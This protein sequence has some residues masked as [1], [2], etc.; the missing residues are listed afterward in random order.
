MR[1]RLRFLPIA[2]FVVGL[3]LVGVTSFQLHTGLWLEA[4]REIGLAL[5][6][7]G[8]ATLTIE[9]VR[10]KQFSE[11]LQ[12]AVATKLLEIERISADAIMRGPLPRFY[13]EHIKRLML[14]KQTYR[15]GWGINLRLEPAADGLFELSYDQAYTVKNLSAVVHIYELEFLETLD[16][17][18]TDKSRIRFVKARFEHSPHPEV[19]LEASPGETIGNRTEDAIVFRQ[20][21]PMNQG[22]SL[23]VEE[24]SVGWVRSSDMF[25]VPAADP[26][27]GIRCTMD[28]PSTVRVVFEFPEG[29]TRESVYLAAKRTEQLRTGWVRSSWDYPFPIVPSVAIICSWSL[30]STPT[31]SAVTAATDVANAEEPAA[32]A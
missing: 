27:D 9:A 1:D 4:L 21:I 32:S 28:H 23:V 13:Y 2:V 3:L 22:M 19:F 8:F 30:E 26:A 18:F 20:S 10:V 24:G 12:K 14:L 5:A 7:V 17:E 25:F 29:P 16:G 6:I 15:T 11:E 31:A